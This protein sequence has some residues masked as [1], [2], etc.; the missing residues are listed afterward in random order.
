MAT[1]I[2]GKLYRNVK[3]ASEGIETNSLKVNNVSM[4]TL[5]TG[6]SNKGKYL[7]SNSSTGALEWSAVSGGGTQLYKHRISFLMDDPNQ[8]EE[9]VQVIAEVI[10]TTSTSLVGQGVPDNTISGILEWDYSYN[11]IVYTDEYM[12]L[13]YCVSY[14]E[15]LYIGVHGQVLSDTV[16]PL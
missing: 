4:D 1:Q 10:N 13:W 11:P 6:A 14:Q 9:S 16:T 2:N 3:N 12:I 5:A 7:H 8:E 15:F